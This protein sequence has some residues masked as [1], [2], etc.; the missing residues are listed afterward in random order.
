MARYI[1]RFEIPAGS[2]VRLIVHGG[3]FVVQGGLRRDGTATGGVGDVRVER[4]ENSVAV[5]VTGSAS[6]Q[7]PAQTPLVI[8]GEWDDAVI[9]GLHSRVDLAGGEGELRL[10]DLP[11]EVLVGDIGD[12]LVADSVGTLRLLGSAGGDVALRRIGVVDGRDVQGDLA[13]T[14]VEELTLGQVEGDASL[15]RIGNVRVDRVEGDLAVTRVGTLRVP[16][17]G[18]DARLTENEGPVEIGA[19]EGDLDVI[20]PGAGIQA[21][22]VMGDLELRGAVAAG[23]NCRFQVE[24]DALVAVSGPVR[25]TADAGGL[26]R[27]PHRVSIEADER[28][29]FVGVIGQG[30]PQGG[31]E[32]IA[33]GDIRV[34]AGRGEGP[35]AEFGAERIARE[36]ERDVRRTVN[37]VE[38][39]IRRAMDEVGRTMAEVERATATPAEAHGAWR[40]GRAWRGALAKWLQQFRTGEPADASPPPNAND[41]SDETLAVLRMVQ[42]GTIT[43]EE[44]EKLLDAMGE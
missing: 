1:Q 19:V 13:V 22:S 38:R 6:V 11:G 32:V 29:R 44:A 12:D 9:Q 34:V 14:D 26:L 4:S 33:E 35:E 36:V 23:V 2:T 27:A 28:Q 30:E 41:L 10:R 3:D 8:R 25:L 15:L 39:E 16:S 31:I 7:L 17:V 37:E 5:E 40:E 24:G 43:A 42:S 20:H 18:G 21:P